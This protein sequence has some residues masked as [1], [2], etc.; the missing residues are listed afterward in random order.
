[1]RLPTLLIT[2]LLAGLIPS[3]AAENLPRTPPLSPAD[4]AKS[5]RILHA[6]TMDLLAAEPLV[7]DPVA[8]AYDEDGR[9]YVCEMNDYPYTDK[10]HHK[11]GQ[12]NPTDQPIGKVRLLID[13]DGDG[14][15]DRATVFA[16]G[17]SWPTGIACWNGGVFVAATPDIWYFKDT[18]GDG[19]ADVR[20][21]VFTGF[22]KLNVQAVMNNLVWGL[23]N[24]LYGAGGTNGG[25]LRSAG[26]K[27][28]HGANADGAVL[29]GHGDFAFDPADPAGTFA[30]LSGGARF[31]NTF[32]DWGN[33]FLCNIRNPA[34]HVVLPADALA[35]NPS[36]AVKSPL[37]DVA[38]SGDQVPVYRVSPVEPWRE[39]RARRWAG[40][41]DTIMP[42]SELV[43]AGVVTSSSGVTVYRGAAYPADFYG[44][45]FTAES[46]GNLFYRQKLTPQ[47][48]TFSA[49]RIDGKQEMVASTDLWFRAVNFVNAPDGTLHVCDMYREVIEH[50]W[51]IP[52]DI[53]AALDLES[54]RDRGRLWRLTPPG[55]QQPAPPR[56]GQATT[57]ELVA[58]LESPNSWWRETAQRL[59]FE[60]QDAAA[61]E[62]LRKLLRESKSPLGRLHATW[63]LSGLQKL[64]RA[65]LEV[66]LTDA[67]AGVRA[68][69]LRAAAEGHGPMDRVYQAAPALAQDSAA[70]V[71]FQLALALGVDAQTGVAVPRLAEILRRDAN[72][73]WMVAAVMSSSLGKEDRLLADIAD[74]P[75]VPDM[76]VRQLA[77]LYASHAPNNPGTTETVKSLFAKR[78]SAEVML[79]IAE[80]FKRAKN[81]L[82]AKGLGSILT[83]AARIAKDGEAPPEKRETA[84]LLLGFDDF[85][86]SRE[87]LESLLDPRE[88]QQV[89][90]AAL[91]A[92]AGFSAP[93]V[94]ALLLQH[95]P[96][97]TPALRTEMVQALLGVKNR[98]VP[99]LDAIARG[100]IPK[101]QIPPARRMLLLRSKDPEILQRLEKLYGNEA[102]SPRSEVIAKYQSALTLAGDPARG[103]KIFETHCQVC[104]RLGALGNDIGPNLASVR[105]WSPDQ[106]LVN[107]LDPNREVAPNYLQYAFELRSG[108]TI[109]GL[110]VDETPANLT[111]R[112][113]DNAVQTIL[114]TDLK[115]TT[116]LGISLMPE[117]LEAAVTPQQM[118]DLIAAIKATE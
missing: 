32:D 67:A 83:D 10:A 57:A 68:N 97:S 81:S 52:D 80:G 14:K 40:E 15:F 74:V 70:P 112:R 38:E 104:H 8:M 106:L 35:R 99:F 100:D 59:L 18:D 12:E 48:V 39:V 98:L 89:Q 25:E 11:S 76:I 36:F 117:G 29:L 71:R 4:A 78:P 23:D 33:R 86:Q 45:I 27:P 115:T 87:M 65:D 3:G 24:R 64:E 91:H 47:G 20:E 75:E 102:A 31:G 84:T 111:V 94:G 19:V 30:L 69:A 53:H 114:R 118:A 90:I 101:N 105:Q 61:V 1:M 60:Q 49:S 56:L 50:P 96:Q 103:R 5:F 108:E 116:G 2:A 54:G 88:P 93:E 62:P 46:A 113:P 42:R 41:R 82:R 95:W 6:F 43:G 109:V 51:S 9:A 26:P 17:L 107:I 16:E 21:K 28:L 58:A 22:K 77:A 85:A 66:A 55:F 72:D 92:L 44:N 13:D 110:L 73:P 79:G 63:S 37:Q 34:Q 7:T